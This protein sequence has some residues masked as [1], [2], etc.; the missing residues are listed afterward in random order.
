MY[1]SFLPYIYIYGSQSS[2]LLIAQTA[3]AVEN[4]DC[5]SAES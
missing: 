2:S 4:A 1:V 3:R 5:T